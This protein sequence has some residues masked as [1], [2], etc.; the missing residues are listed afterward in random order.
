MAPDIWLVL[1]Q[2][3]FC[4][5]LGD[6][7]LSFFDESLSFPVAS[8]VAGDSCTDMFATSSDV[9]KRL[10]GAHWLFFTSMRILCGAFEAVLAQS[11]LPGR[12]TTVVVDLHLWTDCLTLD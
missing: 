9:L 10:A 12:V 6:S 7:S 11:P 1:Y 2:L 4:R 3:P 8:Q 5:C